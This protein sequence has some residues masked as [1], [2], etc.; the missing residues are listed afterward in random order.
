MAL[1]VQGT[2]AHLCVS[3]ACAGTEQRVQRHALGHGGRLALGRQWA[4]AP[5]EEASPLRE[6][7]VGTRAQDRAGLPPLS[8]LFFQDIL[9]GHEH[10]RPAG[11]E[12]G[13]KEDSETLFPMSGA[14]HGVF[15]SL[16]LTLG[17]MPRH[18]CL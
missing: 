16:V 9:A 18:S 17:C 8:C 4:A 15:P 1:E 13:A 10:S 3:P 14:A 7:H 2:R 6:S 12:T 5:A 11:E